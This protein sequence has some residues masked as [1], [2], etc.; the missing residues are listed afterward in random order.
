MQAYN[1]WYDGLPGGSVAYL[2]DVYLQWRNLPSTYCTGCTVI[3]N[4][5]GVPAAKLVMGIPASTSAAIASYYVTSA[6]IDQYLTAMSTASY[7]LAGMM[8]WDSHWDQLNQFNISN[9]IIRGRDY[10]PIDPLPP[11]TPSLC[12]TTAMSTIRYNLL[13]ILPIIDAA[14]AK[15]HAYS[16]VQKS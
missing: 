1:N 7:T 9:T 2:T 14:A 5:S 13:P 3:A 8:I 6:V 16:H 15:I 10:N 11:V 4:F 12:N